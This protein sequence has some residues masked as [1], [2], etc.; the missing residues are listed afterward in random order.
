MCFPFLWRSPRFS[1]KFHKV[2]PH[3]LAG[4]SASIPVTSNLNQTA[5]RTLAQRILSGVSVLICVLA[6]GI[7]F[8][9]FR[10]TNWHDVFENLHHISRLEIGIALFFVLCSYG[11]IACYDVLAFEYI[12][13]KLAVQKITFASLITYSISPNVGFAFLSGSMLRYRL[14][15]QWQISNFD[16]AQIIA[17]TNFN[18]WVGLIPISGLV[19]SFSSFSLPDII[20]L[21]LLVK[22]L[23]S[24]GGILL[25]MSGIYLG[26]SYWLRKPLTWKQYQIQFPSLAISIK[27]I[28]IFGLD[29]GFAALALYYL[30][31]LPIDYPFFFG[32][33]VVAMIAGLISTIPGGLGIFETVILF[34]FVP[35]KSQEVILATLIVFRSL[36]YFL[37]FAIA[38]AALLGFE[39]WQAKKVKSSILDD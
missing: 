31:E 36:Y 14:Y 8:R 12:N 24:F 37:P 21:P 15:R 16:I 23:E 9:E 18:L 13:K 3:V 20:R 38:V 7:I 33:Y 4:L 22:S 28:I 34:F 1:I 35:L 17:F 29:W 11:A 25:I 26:L 30:L 5:Q 6:I 27:Q 32:A 19:L 39:F 10:A 2:F